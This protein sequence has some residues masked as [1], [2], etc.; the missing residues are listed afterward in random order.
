MIFK[1]Y[2]DAHHEPWNYPNRETWRFHVNKEKLPN[3]YIYIRKDILEFGLYRIYYQI[4]KRGVTVWFTIHRG[5]IENEYGDLKNHYSKGIHFWRK[6]YIPFR[7][8][9]SKRIQLD[10]DYGIRC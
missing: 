8:E 6:K 1:L 2:R 3:L 9:N 5:E 7:S 10:C 4:S